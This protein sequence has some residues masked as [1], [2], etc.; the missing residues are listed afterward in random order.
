MKTG[1]SIFVNTGHKSVAVE[2][3]VAISVYY[4]KAYYLLYTIRYDTVKGK[5]KNENRVAQKKRLGNSPGE[6]RQVAIC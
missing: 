4:Y 6:S 3:T 2:R 1:V 5:T